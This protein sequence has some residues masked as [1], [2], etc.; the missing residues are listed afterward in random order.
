MTL[1]AWMLNGQSLY[2]LSAHI[3]H[4]NLYHL[5]SF[6]FC[7]KV[8]PGGIFLFCIYYNAACAVRKEFVLS[9]LTPPIS[10]VSVSIP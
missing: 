8:N 9:A 7:R 6:L 10:P 3:E 4:F 5:F 1:S 2:R